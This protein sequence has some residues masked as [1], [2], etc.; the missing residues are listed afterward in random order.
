M[1]GS[2]TQDARG[3]KLLQPNS[4]I[5]FFLSIV[6]FHILKAENIHFDMFPVYDVIDVETHFESCVS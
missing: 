5:L 4:F 2:P 3:P 1:S 6:H